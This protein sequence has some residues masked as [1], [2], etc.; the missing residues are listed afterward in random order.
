[1]LPLDM[2]QELRRRPTRKQEQLELTEYSRRCDL[3][4]QETAYFQHLVA[5]TGGANGWNLKRD[6]EM[7]AQQMIGIDLAKLPLPAEAEELPT[8]PEGLG[9]HTS[10]LY[11][12][13]GECGSET[14][15]SAI[16]SGT[17]EQAKGYIS[18]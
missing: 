17:V 3:K 12:N 8:P 7:D 18:A 4:E 11:D 13:F 6:S 5:E 14:Y 2:S 15:S 10:L 16:S 9:A 1:M